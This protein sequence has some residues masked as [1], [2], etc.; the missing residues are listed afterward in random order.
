MAFLRFGRL[1]QQRKVCCGTKMAIKN[2]EL[3]KL[4][5][6]LPLPKRS[7]PNLNNPLLKGNT[8][9]FGAFYLGVAQ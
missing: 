1:I 3:Q 4:D 7:V 2:G 6:A 8:E 5:T 9:G